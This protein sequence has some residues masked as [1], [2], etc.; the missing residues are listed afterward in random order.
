M[1]QQVKM[2]VTHPIMCYILTH[3]FVFKGIEEDFTAWKSK[4]L[5]FLTEGGGTEGLRR[6]ACG[7]DD[8]TS[9]SCCRSQ[10]GNPEHPSAV[11]EDTEVSI[12]VRTVRHL[13]RLL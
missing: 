13:V 7:K 6:C 4:L 10:D 1:L 5:K 3:I 11:S 8:V 9:D 2:E 12:Y